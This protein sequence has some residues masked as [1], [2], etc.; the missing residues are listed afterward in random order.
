MMLSLTGCGNGP[1]QGLD[2]CGPWRAI[3]LTPQDQLS[4]ATAAD[5]LGHNQTGVRLNCWATPTVQGS[6]R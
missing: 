6:S 4:R 3:Y 2:V 5:I 1:A